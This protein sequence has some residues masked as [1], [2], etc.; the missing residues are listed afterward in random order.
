M[1]NQGLKQLLTVIHY[2]EIK[3]RL[4]KSGKQIHFSTDLE[5]KFN[6]LVNKFLGKEIKAKIIS[7]YS[8]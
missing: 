7:I 1:K 4:T 8:C 3:S 5:E 2:L 6:A